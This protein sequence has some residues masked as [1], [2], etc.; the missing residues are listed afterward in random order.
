MKEKKRMRMGKKQART[1]V[2]RVNR[3]CWKSTPEKKKIEKK[4]KGRWKRFINEKTG[5]VDQKDG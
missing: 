1:A 4:E 2:K 5:E 3:K